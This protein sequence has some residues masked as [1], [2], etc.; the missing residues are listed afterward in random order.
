MDDKTNKMDRKEA[1]QI[2]FLIIMLGA[3]FALIFCG[4]KIVQYHDMLVNPLGYS[5]DHFN[6]TTCT[7]YGQDGP[8]TVDSISKPIEDSAY[9][10]NKPNFI[11]PTK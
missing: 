10:I 7:C 2:V 3:V 6:I 4:I 9:D 11:I 8:F 1:T 5:L